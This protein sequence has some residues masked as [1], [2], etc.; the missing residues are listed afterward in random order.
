MFS[1]QT[2][3][4]MFHFTR[5]AI[6][7]LRLLTGVRASHFFV[8]STFVIIQENLLSSSYVGPDAIEDQDVHS[9][10]ADTDS[11]WGPK[12]SIAV[13]LLSI[14]TAVPRTGVGD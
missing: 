8:V 11:P 9:R 5:K 13:K 1:F 14:F 3:V 10:S 7:T 12:H 2:Y 4:I 6:L